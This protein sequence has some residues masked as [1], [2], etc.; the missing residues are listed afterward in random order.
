MS[1]LFA[2]VDAFA[3][4]AFTGNPAAICLMKEEKTSD[5]MQKVA[6]EMNLSE[7]A[8][9]L[10]KANSSYTLRWFTPEVEVELCGHATLATAFF[11]WDKGLENKKYPIIFDTL[12]GELKATFLE[13][14]SIELDFPAKYEIESPIIEGLDTSLGLS[15][16][17][18]SYTAINNN[19]YLVVL[20]NSHLVRNLTPC[21]DKISKLPYR[22]V[23]VT[24]QDE[25]KEF[26]IVSRF[27]APNVGVKEDPVTG[28]A[29][30]LLAPF[31]FK[32][33]Q[34]KELNA[35]Q[36]SKRGGNLLLKFD[37]NRVFLQGKA[38]IISSGELYV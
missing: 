2:H 27:F 14:N 19:D 35:Y 20:K 38:V 28:S 30:C 5:W 23:I 25:T 9:A 12:S 24:A 17:D 34:K 13:N 32:R 22:A 3:N 31:W 1:I 10:K 29:H 26:D 18:I 21:F 16:S 8:F 6:F 11:L 15:N 37:N 4:K 33:I 7:T 36:A